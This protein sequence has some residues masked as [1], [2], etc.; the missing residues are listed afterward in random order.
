MK[1][2]EVMAASTEI[3]AAALEAAKCSEFQSVP[4]PPL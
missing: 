4:C 2:N 3:E 1:I